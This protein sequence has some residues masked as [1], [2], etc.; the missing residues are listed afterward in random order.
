MSIASVLQKLTGRQ[1]DICRAAVAIMLA[2]VI[3]GLTMSEAMRRGMHHALAISPGEEIAV[4]IA[5]S[6]T[7]Y[8]VHLGYVGLASVSTQYRPIG[9][10]AE[11]DGP[12]SR[13]WWKISTIGSCLMTASVP[14]RRWAHRRSATL[15]T[16]R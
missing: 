11:M 14:Q 13:Y 3:I 2:A 10:G 9:T 15:P 4:A 7:V 6:D 8:G 1:R 5:L 12:I 16:A